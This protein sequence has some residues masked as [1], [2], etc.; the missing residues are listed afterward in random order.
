M[1]YNW[2][3]D[4]IHARHRTV[5]YMNIKNRP[6]QIAAIFFSFTIL[7]TAQAMNFTAA[8]KRLAMPEI[9][10]IRLAEAFALG[11]NIS[12][13]L[14]TNWN[15]APFAVL[16]VTPDNEYL[17]RHPNP[18]RDFMP[19]G[20]D[21]LLKS[22][23]YGRRRTQGTNLLATFPAIKGSAV[24]TIVVGEAENTGA[25][26][27]T[28]WVVTLLHEHFHQ[29]QYS[30]SNYYAETAALNLAHGDQTG[31]WMLNYA[32]PYENKLVWGQFAALAKLLVETAAS[33][34]SVDHSNLFVAYLQARRQFQQLLSPEDYKYF[35]FQAWQ[36][37]IA[38]YTEFDVAKF[39]AA[40][41]KPIKEFRALKDFT[42]FAE[43]AN[44]IH[45]KIFQQLLTQ[46]LGLSKREMFYPFGAA[47]G[48]LLDAAN[49]SWRN[50]YFEEKFD[51]GK[52]YPSIEL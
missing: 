24:P 7:F 16:L 46:Q 38:R 5:K 1:S 40:E 6:K 27:S 36:E 17:V 11:E 10:R 34:S 35:S 43:V 48:L 26:T 23:V 25:K 49:P 13:H 15:T 12:N 2:S 47:E 37:G 31:M 50:R 19:L 8:R 32:F 18:S 44:S 20:Y 3:N 30:R 14:W 51:L 21:A 28:P 4:R 33:K 42:P 22:D 9:D 52:Y 41:H 29:L 39:A 45:E